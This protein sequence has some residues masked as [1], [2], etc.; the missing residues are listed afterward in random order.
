MN[1]N[2]SMSYHLPTTNSSSKT[3]K[4]LLKIFLITHLHK[5]LCNL[6]HKKFQYFLGKNFELTTETYAMDGKII[7]TLLNEIVRTGEYTLEGIATY[8]KIPL[9]IIV[10]ATCGIT[11]QLS[12]TWTRVVD[13][14]MQVRPDVSKSFY[15]KLIA[16]LEKENLRVSAILNAE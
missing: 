3:E 13:L 10:D 2:S 6:Y 5:F 9:D 12:M 4:R 11:H 7:E 14:Y 15:E 16:E 1:L 8:T